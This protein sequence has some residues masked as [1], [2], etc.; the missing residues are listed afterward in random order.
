MEQPSLSSTI[1]ALRKDA[2]RYDGKQKYGWK[3]HPGFWVTLSYRVRRL[4]KLGATPFQLLLPLDLILALVKTM[5]SDT[6][7]P[8]NLEVGK[9]LYLPHPQGIFFSSMAKIE[10]NCS[11]FQQVT[12]GEW[13][14]KAPIIK[15]G[16]GIFAGAKIFGGVIIGENS[17]IGANCAVNSDIPP[18]STVSMQPPNI[19]EKPN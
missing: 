5:V 12:I 10:E 7:I 16:C 17:K 14:S 13:R 15:S 19:R 3:L 2:E 11:I 9:G 1:E 6:Q 8:S 4:R 18:N